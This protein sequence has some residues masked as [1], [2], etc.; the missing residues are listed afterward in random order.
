MANE[1]LAIR[2]FYLLFHHSVAL[3]AMFEQANSDFD[4]FLF[5]DL[6]CDSLLRN[7][8]ACFVTLIRAP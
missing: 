6:K 1:C 2:D 4:C 5:G 8:V 7:V 3:V